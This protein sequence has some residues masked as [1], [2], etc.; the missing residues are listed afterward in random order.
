MR[1]CDYD[2]YEDIYDFINT[3]ET[4]KMEDR[5]KKHW[6]IEGSNNKFGTLKDAEDEAKKRAQKQNTDYNIYEFVAQAQPVVP[7]VPIVK[8]V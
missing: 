1:D 3:R 2:D 7:D 6:K 4:T 8:I 5:T